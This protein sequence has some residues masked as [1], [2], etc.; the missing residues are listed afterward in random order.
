MVSYMIRELII[1]FLEYQ[2]PCI[3]PSGLISTVT[4]YKKREGRGEIKQGKILEIISSSVKG[5]KR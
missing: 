2:V 1:W 4:C 3:S 5:Y